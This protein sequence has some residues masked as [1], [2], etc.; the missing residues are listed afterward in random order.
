MRDLGTLGGTL[1]FTNGLN[2]RDQVV[3]QS[4]LAGDLIFHPFLWDGRRLLDLGTFGGSTGQA[5]AINDAGAVAGVAD[6]AGDQTHDAFLWENGVMTDL[7]NLGVTSFAHAISSTGQVLGA[8]RI[9]SEGNAR[10]FL[11]ENGGPMID[12]NTLIPSN[13]SLTLVYAYTINERGEIGGSGVPDG[14]QSK[15]VDTCGHAFLLIPDGDCDS[16]CEGRIAETQ[17]RIVASR[18]NAA[19]TQ[20]AATMNQSSESPLSPVERY[21]TQIR[22]RYHLPGQPAAPRD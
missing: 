15:D 6:F 13:S 20:N 2:N 1:S 4:N 5:I 12:L 10:A 21:R 3:G 7:G 8:S 22:Q 17:S 9:D 14:C 11:W 16:H 19:P 18:N